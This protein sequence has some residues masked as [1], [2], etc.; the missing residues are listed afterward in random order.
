ML[1][2]LLLRDWILHRNALVPIVAIFG[3][4]QVYFVLNADKPRLW[5]IFT[6]IYVS[7][8]TVVPFTR[9][10]KFQSAAWSCTLP[11]CRADLVR[12]RYAGAW[13]AVAGGFLVAFSVAVLLPRSK[14]RGVLPVNP[15]S[16]LLA[17]AVV[18]V[19]LLLVLPFTIRFGFVGLVI[20]LA[21]LQILGGVTFVFSKALG[22]QDRV[23]GGVA[24][25][26]RPFID[27][28]LAVRESLSPPGFFLA[29]LVLLIL[30]NW[31]GYRFALALFRRREF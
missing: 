29:A 7:F 23:E 20:G 26:F 10:D 15:E 11:V 5:I 19:I 8:L 27:G 14:L 17:G 4:F 2:R 24:A 12:A 18:T 13:V 9:D 28:I 30:L 25:V 3:A 22:R 31:A 1:R 21:A 16:L 6:S